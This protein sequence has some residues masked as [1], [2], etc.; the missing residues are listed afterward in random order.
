MTPVPGAAGLSMTTEPP[1]FDTISCGIV[2]PLKRDLD[3]VASGLDRTLADGVG[4]GVGL[5]HAYADVAL[6]ISDHHHGVEAQVASALDHL[7]DTGYADDPLNEMLLV[8]VLVLPPRPVLKLAPVLLLAS[9]VLKR[10]PILLL[11][12][13]VSSH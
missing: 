9:P 11:R 4:H 13:V 2:E 10:R 6:F 1:Y 8:R 3:H 12:S 7:G 5:A